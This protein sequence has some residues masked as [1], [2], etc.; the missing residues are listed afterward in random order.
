MLELSDDGRLVQDE[1]IKIPI[2]KELC[3][4]T[5]DEASVLWN[6]QTQVWD[7]KYIQ[8]KLEL[9]K[10][11]MGVND[12]IRQAFSVRGGEVLSVEIE[13]P[14]MTRGLEISVEDMKR[15]EEIFEQFH[16][17][18][19]DDEPPDQTLTQTFNEL[20]QMVEGTE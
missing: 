16:K 17:S 20:I 13:M 18:K 14:E 10:P 7:G 5:G 8:V 2:F 1:A 9:S 4:V 19:F 15:P 3:T 12:K 11:Q 6:A